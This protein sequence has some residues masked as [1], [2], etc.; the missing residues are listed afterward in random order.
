M[1]FW[2][3]SALSI[4]KSR[5]G[6]RIDVVTGKNLMANPDLICLKAKPLHLYSELI[7]DKIAKVIQRA[8]GV[9]S[10]NG[11]RE[12]GFLCRKL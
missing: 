7:F 6:V 2:F 9:F 5:E 12:I 10:T 11:A 3:S 1:K 8:K 4:A